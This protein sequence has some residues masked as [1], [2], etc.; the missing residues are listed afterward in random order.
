VGDSASVSRTVTQ[1]DIELF[2]VISGDVNPAQLDPAYAETNMFHRAIAHGMLGAGLI[3]TVLGTKLPGAGTIYLGQELRFR[4]PVDIGDTITA[5]ATV[6]EKRPEK[7]IVLLDCR[8]T[9]HAGKDVITGTA[10]VIAPSERVRRPRVELPDV[11]LSRHER[12]RT[13][14]ARAA[15]QPPVPTAVAYPCD[16][17]SLG[18][19]AEAAQAGLIAPILVGP[20]TNIRAVALAAGIDI[21]PFRLVDVPAIGAAAEQAVALVRNGEARMLMKGS[22]HTDAL[23]HEV[24]SRDSG[25]RTDRRLS[26]IYLM[27]VPSYSRPLMVTDAEINISP[28]V[29][30]KRDIIQNAINLAHVMGIDKPRVALLSAVETVN[31]KLRSTMEAAALCKMAD[32]GQITGGVLD[33]PLAFD[34]AVSPQAAAEKGIIS[35]VAGQADI[36]VVPD[37]EAGN[38]LAKQ[39]IFLARADAAG[40]VLGARAPIIL[41]SRA[42]GPRTRMASCTVAVLLAHTQ[43]EDPHWASGV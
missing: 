26:H 21:A 7:R 19:A 24:V 2:A 32:R 1:Q 29:E 14:L 3:S 33:G 39:L 22:L 41:T 8:C 43:L 6:T 35:P 15:G 20:A 4:H 36:L 17:L 23:M 31:P 27:D 40:V 28:D 38:M 5:T 18:A 13:L 9:N 25:L 12:F 11:Q 30:A 10:E 42:D 16:T 34:N 37:L